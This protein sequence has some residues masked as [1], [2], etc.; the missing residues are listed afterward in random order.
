M[1]Q[2]AVALIY[3]SLG[4]VERC[5]VVWVRVRCTVKEG[6]ELVDHRGEA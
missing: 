6:K 1:S 4:F 2:L 5:V 3:K